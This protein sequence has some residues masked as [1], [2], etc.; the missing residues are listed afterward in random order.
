MSYVVATIKI[1][2]RLKVEDNKKIHNVNRNIHKD[3]DPYGVHL[4]KYTELYLIY[5]NKL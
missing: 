4:S 5:Y 3:N 2:Y 1:L